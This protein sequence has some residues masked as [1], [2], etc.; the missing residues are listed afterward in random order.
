MEK[1]RGN[2]LKEGRLR[3]G[4]LCLSTTAA[5]G[6]QWGVQFAEGMADHGVRKADFGI[7]GTRD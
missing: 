1:D 2:K 3:F 4:V 7:A 6:G 5:Y